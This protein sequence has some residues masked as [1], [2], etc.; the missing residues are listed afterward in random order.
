M[1]RNIRTEHV[2]DRNQTR[3][4]AT[5]APF[6]SAMWRSIR[7]E[8]AAQNRKEKKKKKKKKKNYFIYLFIYYN[9]FVLDLK[10]LL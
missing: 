9:L 6:Q 3:I 2:G 5:A 8:W 10:L 7:V 1:C 4:S